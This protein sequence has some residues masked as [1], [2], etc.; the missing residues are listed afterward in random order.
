MT[1]Q[2]VIEENEMGF[3]VEELTLDM[4]RQLKLESASGVVIREVRPDSPAA[5]A[6][7]VSRMVILEINRQPIR[8]IDDFNQT[9]AQS[10][11]E[12]GILLFV[13][14][15]GSARYITIKALD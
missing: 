13:S 10:R 6:G 12:E 14:I 11:L 7:L 9:A 1:N 15:E 8:S 5:R 2:E 4:A 3:V